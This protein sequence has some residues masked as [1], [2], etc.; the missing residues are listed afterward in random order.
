MKRIALLLASLTIALIAASC[1]ERD[2]A[3][4]ESGDTSADVDADTDA[5]PDS[6][7]EPVTEE[8][9]TTTVATSDQVATMTTS[10]PLDTA[11]L[12]E[13]NEALD[14]I[15]A[16]F[17]ELSNELGGIASDLAADANAQASSD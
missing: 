16:L 3:V 15:D 6:S 17:A 4:T 1:G 11:S 14:A 12:D 5:A 13:A 2:G 9:S 8:A 7:P 10:P